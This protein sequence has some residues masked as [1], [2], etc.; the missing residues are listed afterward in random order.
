MLPYLFGLL[1]FRLD[2]LIF[3][4]EF[5]PW[6]ILRQ[7][8]SGWHRSRDRAGLVHIFRLSLRYSSGY[9]RYLFFIIIVI[10]IFRITLSSLLVL[11][12]S[13]LPVQDVSPH[14]SS[15]FPY[16]SSNRPD[17]VGSLGVIAAEISDPS[18]FDRNFDETD[19]NNIMIGSEKY[20]NK[21]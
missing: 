19:S 11:Y 9:F 21:P 8:G 3:I 4:S 18:L 20:K 16:L 17:K 12:N 15:H 10:V 14:I 7:C 1:T 13:E 5:L 6:G 2:S